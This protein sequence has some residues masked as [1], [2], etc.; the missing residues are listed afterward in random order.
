MSDDESKEYRAQLAHIREHQLPHIQPLIPAHFYKPYTDDQCEI[1]RQVSIWFP[2]GVYD[3]V[4]EYAKGEQSIEVLTHNDTYYWFGPTYFG[5]VIPLVHYTYREFLK[6]EA[7]ISLGMFYVSN[8]ICVIHRDKLVHRAHLYLD[9][10]FIVH[11]YH[12]LQQRYVL[13]RFPWLGFVQKSHDTLWQL[14]FQVEY[15]DHA[16]YYGEDVFISYGSSLP[17]AQSSRGDQYSR[18][19]EINCDLVETLSSEQLVDILRRAGCAQSWTRNPFPLHDN[20]VRYVI[21]HKTGYYNSSFDPF[22]NHDYRIN[23]FAL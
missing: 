15:G 23:A 16:G 13:L 9:D 22:A 7:D 21:R 5:H 14:V 11:Y 18:V 3:I 17:S 12:R 19:H 8:A 10:C 6:P 1:K 4:C 20:D 2:R